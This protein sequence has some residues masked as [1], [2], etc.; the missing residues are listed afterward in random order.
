MSTQ[1]QYAEDNNAYV[2]ILQKLLPIATCH[3]CSCPLSDN[4][5]ETLNGSDKF[6]V[7][8]YAEWHMGSFW[9]F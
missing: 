4:Q 5:E 8:P 2:Y 3:L 1:P 7:Y 6:Q 9:A